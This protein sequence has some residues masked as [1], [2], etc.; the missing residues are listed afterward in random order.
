[1]TGNAHAAADGMLEG[2]TFLPTVPVAVDDI[3]RGPIA[4]HYTATATLDPEK[5]ADVLARISGMILEIA[6]EEGDLVQKDQVLLCIE[7]DEY[8][9]RLKQAEAAEVMQRARYERQK[10]MFEKDLISADEYDTIKSDVQAAEAA[11]ELATLSLSYAKV[12][13]PFSG[14]IVR[15]Y[16]DPGQMVSNGTGLFSVV[17]MSRLLARVH[18][19][20]KVFRRIEQEQAVELTLD[21]DK[22]VLNGKIILVS[23]VI[24][25]TSGTIKVTV[26]I[27]EYPKNTRPGDFAEV[28]IV[29]ERHE[30][31]MLVPRVAV[32]NDKGVDVVFLAEE[33]RAARRQ[34]TTGFQNEQFIEIRSGLSGNE[35]II[36]QGQRSLKDGQPIRILDAIEFE[37]AQ[38]D[39]EST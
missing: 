35:M 32:I 34:V 25:P 13:A 36:V 4:S 38:D 11:R 31:A 22:T 5:Q 6:V 8:Y 21:S 30:N 14:R 20:A 12:K 19:P 1:M 29:T 15:R 2:A 18:V 3:Q 7:E 37:E 16:V 9:Q 39:Q 28:R 26:A 10:K 17:D 23:P 27:T 24:D 33:D